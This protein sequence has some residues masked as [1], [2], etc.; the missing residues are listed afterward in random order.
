MGKDFWNLKNDQKKLSLFIGCAGI[1]LTLGMA[2]SS[3]KGTELKNGNM[4]VKNEPGTGS[5]DQALVAQIADGEKISLTVT[6]EER[7]LTM[8]EAE[9]LFDSASVCLDEIVLGENESF[10]RIQSDL[11]FVNKIPDMMVDVTWS[12]SE[13][14]HADGKVREDRNVTEPVE[15]KLSAVLY[16]QNYTRDYEKNII[17]Y[18]KIR[19]LQS[20][21]LEEI[22][23]EQTESKQ[24]ASLQ[25]PTEYEGNQIV[26]RK[27]WDRRFLYFAGFMLCAMIFLKAGAKRD[28]QLEKQKRLEELERDYAQIVSKFSMLLTAGLSVRNAWERIVRMDQNRKGE[29]KQITKEM[30]WALREFQKGISEL[31][32]YE[33]FGRNVGLVHYKKLMAMFSSHKKRGGSELMQMMNQE[34]LLAWEEKKRKVRQQG[35]KIGTKLL[36]PM[37]GMLA[38]VFVMILVPAFSAFQL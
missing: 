14:F 25:L 12:F 17:L 7:E 28:E 20:S 24:S 38:I 21:L 4:L 35:E 1:L 8:E 23:K 5:Y 36:L 6:V 37:L 26:W 22:K 16:C 32:I 27:P 13:Y 2:I 15:V 9:K 30:N 34:M 3:Y 11:Q 19:T 10:E 18:P 29:K 33:H 31:E